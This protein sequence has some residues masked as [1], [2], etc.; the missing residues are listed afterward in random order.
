MYLR[1]GSFVNGADFVVDGDIT[2]G[3]LLSGEIPG[4]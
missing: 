2:V 4:A 1:V 3:M